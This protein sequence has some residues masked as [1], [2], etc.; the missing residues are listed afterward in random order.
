MKRHSDFTLIELLVVIA[1][2]AILAAMLLPALSA[3]RESA[4]SAKC[5]GTLKQLGTAIYMYAGDNQS[6]VP[7]GLRKNKEAVGVVLWCDSDLYDARRNTMFYLLPAG[8]YFP[9]T[10]SASAPLNETAEGTPVFRMIRDRYFRCPSDSRST[11]QDLFYSTSYVVFLAN[12]AC[13]TNMPGEVYGDEK[14]V[15]TII[16]QD[17]PDNTLMIDL[18]PWYENTYG[19]PGNHPA[20]SNALHLDGRVSSFNHKP[21]NQKAG[22]VELIGRYVDNIVP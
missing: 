11:L 15:R 19:F 4:R 9:E 12:R 10:D 2:I 20:D 21:L 8:G 1:I 16:G 22:Y 14:G 18:F 6:S 17:P 13:V 7:C 3:A 5:I